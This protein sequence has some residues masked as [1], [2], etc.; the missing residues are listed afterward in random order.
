MRT[1][2]R[3]GLRTVAVF[4]DA[5]ARAL[6]VLEADDAVH[7]G[8]SLAADSYLNQA[9]VLEAARSSGARAIH[10]GYGFLSENAAFAQAVIDSG[11]AWIGPPP[12]AM[13]AL[14]D[15]A[16]AKALAEMHEVP[17]LVGYHG[18]DQTPR[19]LQTHADRVGYPLMIKAS[20][21]GGGRGMRVVALPADFAGALESAQREARASFG[22]DHVLLE[23]YVARPRHIEVQIIGDAHGGLIY[24]GERECS[25]Q[26]R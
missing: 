19:T 14:G 21:G 16:R 24:L 22:D 15:K 5:D 12:S 7:I 20:A 11:I 10:P 1:C 4:S 23:R 3:L 13:R 8:G 17:V 25:V 9:H 18:D 6:H 2:R 26:R